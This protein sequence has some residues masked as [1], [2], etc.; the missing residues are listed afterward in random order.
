MTTNQFQFDTTQST[1]SSPNLL[2]GVRKAREAGKTVSGMLMEIAKLR[3]GPGK[4]KPDEYFMYQLYDDTR[5]NKETR[6]TFISDSQKAFFSPWRVIGDDKPL[7]TSLLDGMGLPVP[8]TQ[9]TYHKFRTFGRTIPLRNQEDLVLFLREQAEYPVFGKPCNGC[10]S[11]GTALINSYD[12]ETDELIISSTERVPVTEFAEKVD[13]LRQAYMFQTLLRPHEEITKLIGPSVSCVRMFFI[14]DDRGC[15]LIRAGWKIPA[16][17]N[18][19]DNFWREGNMLAGIDTE[20]GKIVKALKRHDGGT[21]PADKHPETGAAFDGMVF[22]EW[23]K[24]LEV[25]T[26]A[27]Q[28]L[29]DCVF[30]GWDIALTDRGPVILELES[31]GGSP[32][33]GQLCYDRGVLDERY[34]HALD[35]AMNREKR[36]LQWH[37]EMAMKPKLDKMKGTFDAIS[38]FKAAQ[39]GLRDDED[40]PESDSE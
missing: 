30:Q 7:M 29:T 20:S 26:T 13:Q 11:K 25:A 36:E 24:M 1:T 23:D 6:K 32:A 14:S 16:S 3:M 5:F 2:A 37:K 21:I 18:T 4:L 9:A 39:E 33:L 38:R 22:P 10:R 12:K 19:A 31:D 40:S 15:D 27:A 8:E 35:F 17:S 28:N 34:R